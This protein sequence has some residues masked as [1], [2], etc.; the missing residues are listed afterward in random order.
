MKSKK[1]QFRNDGPS[2]SSRRSLIGIL[3]IAVVLIGVITVL[4]MQ[5][6][7]ESVPMV[8]TNTPEVKQPKTKRAGRVVTTDKNGATVVVDQQTGDVRPLTPEEASRLAAGLKQLINNT[9]EGLVQI[10]QKD[11]TVSMDLDG[12][13]QNVVLAKKED[14]GSVSQTCV[15][16]L[17]AASAF[18][19]IDPKL[20]GIT[21]TRVS[22]AAPLPIK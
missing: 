21:T 17:E 10:E 11:G 13:F 3:A 15:D 8:G 7:R 4:S 20:L 14:D 5:G 2:G 9:D 1:S 12:H 19:A 22:P 6:H 18:F 16:N